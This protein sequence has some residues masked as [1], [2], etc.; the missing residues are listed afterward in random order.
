MKKLLVLLITATFVVVGCSSEQAPVTQNG[1]DL[2]VVK[3]KSASGTSKQRQHK[4]K[5]TE[6]AMEA[7]QA[8]S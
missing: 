1:T 8:G 7:A 2:V 3:H 6:S 4:K 5:K